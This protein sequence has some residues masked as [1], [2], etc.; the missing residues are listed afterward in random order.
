M[1]S[2]VE[3]YAAQAGVI[4]ELRIAII[5]FSVAEEQSLKEAADRLP[6]VQMHLIP[7][8]SAGEAWQHC[9]GRQ[10]DAV[11]VSPSCARLIAAGADSAHPLYHL[12]VAIVARSSEAATSRRL[13]DLGFR[14]IPAAQAPD[15]RTLLQTALQICLRQL[16]QRQ[17]ELLDE[18]LLAL[19]Q[20]DTGQ[21]ENALLI[22]DDNLGTRY[23]NGAAQNL[24]RQCLQSLLERVQRWSWPPVE[25]LNEEFTACG[26]NAPPLRLSAARVVLGDGRATI[27]KLQG[28]L[29]NVLQNLPRPGSGAVRSF[30][31]TRQPASAR[32]SVRHGASDEAQA[33]TLARAVARDEFQTFF[34]PV[35]DG[36]GQRLCGAEALLRWNDGGGAMRLPDDFL[37]RLEQ[38]DLLDTISLRTL[39]EACRFARTW[40]LIGER[41]FAVS[42]NLSPAQIHH[43]DL[44]TELQRILNDT[45]IGEHVLGVEIPGHVPIPALHHALPQLRAWA[46]LGVRIVLDGFNSSF[47]LLRSLKRLP[48]H[49]IKLDRR[50][51]ARVAAERQDR[52]IAASIVGLAHDL[53]IVV[54]AQGVETVDQALVLR[55]L[56]VDRQQGFLFGPAMAQEE[57][58][59]RFL[60]LTERP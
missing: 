46:A 26:W 58:G 34:Q 8:T 22:L 12:S 39:R 28:P 18:A 32:S 41:Q 44:D 36:N 48:I 56:G 51:C 13:I 42:V 31:L 14:L 27:V 49:T 1:N 20:A 52:L 57:F 15:P 55:D 50:L 16:R 24:P 43:P 53:G 7:A 10:P 6:E 38:H 60:W 45:G 3:R 21:A 9:H 47:T 59:A 29:P 33:T 23:A 19:E 5:G 40:H 37:S 2:K 25:V 54:V 30:S 11:L 17:T 35:V 4:P